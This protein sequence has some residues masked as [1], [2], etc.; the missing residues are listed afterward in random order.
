MR[1]MIHSGFRTRLLK[2]M[3]GSLWGVLREVL[4]NKFVNDRLYENNF[5]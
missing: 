2:E 1:H 3:T 4:K 5:A